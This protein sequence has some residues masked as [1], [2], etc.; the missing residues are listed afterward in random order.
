MAKIFRKKIKQRADKM[1]NAWEEGA[2]DAE[3]M[4]H[5]QTTFVTQMTA[6]GTKEG[7][8]DDLLAQAGLIDDEL[9]GMYSGLD[10]TMVAVRNGVAGHKDYGN[11]SPLYGAMGFIRKSERRSGLTRKKKN[12]G[13]PS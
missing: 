11:D 4:G 5:T 1:N 7:E 8:R 10:D 9:D 2:K 6:I 3:F 13:S 12:G